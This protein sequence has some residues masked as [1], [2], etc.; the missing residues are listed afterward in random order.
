MS[1][2]DKLFVGTM[3]DMCEKF[4][5]EMY[6]YQHQISQECELEFVQSSAGNLQ[7]ILIYLARP[8]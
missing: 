5:V 1:I 4:K 2:I 7:N 8:T 3:S 6:K